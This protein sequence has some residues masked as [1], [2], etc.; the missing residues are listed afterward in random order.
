[1]Y[2]SHAS[3][4]TS[5]V[6]NGALSA[7]VSVPNRQYSHKRAIVERANPHIGNKAIVKR[8]NPTIGD[9]IDV[10]D[11]QRGGKLIPREN[12]PTSGAFSNAFQLMN[13]VIT[14]TGSANDAIFA[15]YFNDEDKEVVLNVFRRLYGF[16]D[17]DDT[18][19]E[20]NEGAAALANIKIIAGEDDPD[21][22]APAFLEDFADEFPNL[23][24]RDDA[25]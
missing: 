5:I 22:P 2:L 12:L 25:W 3:L 17:D 15:K 8:A 19:D 14:S 1:M 11:P 23:I 20:D 7:A 21:D 6:L 16:E 13:Y 9:G 24:L 10:N 4:L 18:G